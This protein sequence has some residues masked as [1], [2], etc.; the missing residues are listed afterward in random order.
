MAGV[1]EMKRETSGGFSS[2]ELLA[3]EEELILQKLDAGDCVALGEIAVRIARA[4]NLPVAIDWVGTTGWPQSV[5]DRLPC[6]LPMMNWPVVSF[7]SSIAAQ[8]AGCRTMPVDIS[9]DSAV[10]SMARRRTS[11]RVTGAGTHDFNDHTLVPD[12]AFTG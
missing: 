9:S 6:G 2:H 3:E 4:K 5:G 1:T 12:Q 11:I 7:S 10:C 8:S